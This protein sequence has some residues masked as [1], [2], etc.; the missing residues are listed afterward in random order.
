[1]DVANIMVF[2]GLHLEEIE[3]KHPCGYITERTLQKFLI[4]REEVGKS[5]DFDQLNEALERLIQAG[6]LVQIKGNQFGSFYK[7]YLPDKIER[8]E[9]VKKEDGKV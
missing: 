2:A 7:R 9:I 8:K 3:K 4:K 6:F 5:V 1:M